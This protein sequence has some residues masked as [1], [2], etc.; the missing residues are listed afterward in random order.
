[1]SKTRVKTT[2]AEE[3]AY[4]STEYKTLYCFHNHSCDYTTFYNEDGSIVEMCFGEW[5]S[6]NDLYD[7]VERLWFPFKDEWGG[8]LKDDVQYYGVTPWENKDDK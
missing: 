1:M 5:E 7:A 2:Y 8:E 3:G 4:G 6:G